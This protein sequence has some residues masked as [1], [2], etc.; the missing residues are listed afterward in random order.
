LLLLVIFVP[1][2]RLFALR[3][4]KVFRSA[5]LPDLGYYF[6]SGLVPGLLLTMPFCRPRVGSA[7]SGA[8]RAARTRGAIGLWNP[9]EPGSKEIPA[10]TLKSS[11]T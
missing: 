11:P 10:A 8:G 3:R 4:Q 6:L 5:F 2:E 1:L 9:F 7:F